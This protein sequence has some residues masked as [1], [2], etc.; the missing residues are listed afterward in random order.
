MRNILNKSCRKN[1][2]FIYINFFWE[3][4][5]VYEIMLKTM[6]EPEV[7]RMTSQYGVYELHA[8]QARLH[9]G[10]RIHTPTHP[11]TRMNARARTHT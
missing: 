8:G 11:G 6:V 4:S 10:K 7:S 3:N 9:A 1:T 5:A 2:H